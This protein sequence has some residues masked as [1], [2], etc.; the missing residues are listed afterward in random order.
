M[1]LGCNRV[2]GDGGNSSDHHSDVGPDMAYFLLEDDS[3]VPE[4][5]TVADA[6]IVI[7]SMKRDLGE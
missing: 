1:I 4:L 7:D 2:R 3:K 5:I 6:K